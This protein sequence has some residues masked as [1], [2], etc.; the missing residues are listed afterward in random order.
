MKILRLDIEG[1]RSLRNVTWE[2]GDLNILIGPNASGKTNLIN[3]LELIAVSAKGKLSEHVLGQGGIA[4]LL[5]DQKAENIAIQVKTSPV[6][7]AEDATSHPLRYVLELR[8]LGSTSSYR[9]DTEF[10]NEVWDLDVDAPR[11]FQRFAE[12]ASIY[13]LD[14]QKRD[15][16]DKVSPEESLLSTL[17]GPFLENRILTGFQ[18]NLASWVVYRELDT[19]RDA[20]IR[21]PVVTRYDTRVAQDGQNLVSVLHTFYTRDREFKNEIDRGMKAAFGEAYERLEFSPVADQRIQLGIWFRGLHR[22]SSA[23]DLSD[24]TLRFLF[25][26][27]ILANPQPPSLIAIEEPEVGLHPGML[28][29]VAEFAADAANRSQVILTTHSPEF[30]D[31]FRDCCP[32]TTILGCFNG[33]TKL[34]MPT[35]EQLKIWMNHYRLGEFLRSGEFDNWLKG[36]VETEQ[37]RANSEVRE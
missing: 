4:P 26:L 13:Y 16:S 2:P 32:T 21:G 20:L 30:L 37:E 36:E 28:P 14:A 23:A 9:V 29:I 18:K 24:G 19:G 25:L 35:G 12:S 5:W 10:L 22:F 1:Y 17:T 15:V 27:T 8:R 11:F 33:E 31:S 6:D 7:P 3:L 34:G